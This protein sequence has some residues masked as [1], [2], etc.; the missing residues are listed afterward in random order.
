MIP[1]PFLPTPHAP[2]GLP[3]NLASRLTKTIALFVA[4]TTL[5]HAQTVQTLSPE[6]NGVAAAAGDLTMQITY[7]VGVSVGTG[8]VTVTDLDTSLIVETFDI[9]DPADATVSGNTVTFRTFTA[10]GGSQYNVEAPSGFVVATA[11]AN[12]APGFGFNPGDGIW[13]FDV[14]AADA[15]GPAVVSLSPQNGA[16]ASNASTLSVTYDENVSLGA[17]SWT[18]TVFDVTGNQLVETFTEA[19]TASV[20][21]LGTRLSFTLAND[22][23]FNNAYR[24]T[25]SAGVVMDAVGN[26]SSEIASGGWEFTTGDP[27]TKGQVVISQV[28]G[29]GGN[30]GATWKNDFVE[31]HN[32]SSSPISLEG[33]SVQYA[34]AAGAFSVANNLVTLSGTIAAG[35]YYLVQGAQGT[36]GTQDLPTPD[37][38]GLMSLAGSNGKVLLS[39]ASA[40][41]GT[42]NPLTEPTVSDLV[43]YGSASPFEGSAAAPALSNTTAAFR[44]VN[45]SQ[46]TNDN[47]DDFTTGAPAPR[48]SASPPFIQGN[49]GSGIASVSNVSGDAGIFLGTKL[50]RSSTAARTVQINLAGSKADA[51]IE[52]VEID[53]PSDFATLSEPNI[54]ITGAAAGGGSISLSG[55]TIT[56]SGVAMTT[57][58]ALVVSISGLTTP[59][60]A[61][62][63]TDSGD[64]T[65]MMRTATSGGTPT[66]LVTSPTVT[67][68]VPVADLAELRGFDSSDK[69]F[70][71]PNE[72]LVT[73]FDTALFFRNQHYIQDSTAGILIDDSPKNLGASYDLGDGLTNLVGKLSTFR[74]I[75]QFNPILATPSASSTGNTPQPVVV[76]LADLAANPEAYESRLVRVNA[77]TFQD[78]SGNFTNDV[79]GVLVQESDTFGFRPFTATD[80]TG[81]AIPSES[82]DLVGLSRPLL[83]GIN[84]GLSP[85]SLADFITTP[86]TQPVYLDWAAEFAG[87]GAANEDFDNDGVPNGLEYFFGVNTPGFTPTPGIV[88]GQITFPRDPSLTDVS[89]TVQTSDDLVGWED[90]LVENLDLSDPNSITYVLPNA[91]APFFVR[92]RV[93]VAPPAVP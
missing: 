46:D 31:L 66:E 40:L 71:I 13:I 9:T 51:V 84:S 74:G 18:I 75:L 68:A 54:S 89:F 50:F 93:I 90:V 60:A 29:G 57:T 21:P 67:I 45:G 49:D 2:K 35:G 38:S 36:G 91:P 17:G 28:Y 61:A 77:V 88:N 70:L 47:R 3:A 30:S 12:P 58:D 1:N 4:A 81:T 55:Q 26:L 85:R 79:E 73:F 34:S 41:I 32:R 87:G 83:D 82:L 23:A 7:D 24:V 56:I 10:V 63:P 72:V 80:Y 42:A 15:T 65:F 5:S 76:T 78:P 53:V 22:L 6:N 39:N 43:A 14:V 19:D 62:V 16:G 27:F 11:G 59:D 86:V 92:I 52:T 37:A 69:T 8:S 44:L 33:W 64:R 48:N 25:F 20:Q